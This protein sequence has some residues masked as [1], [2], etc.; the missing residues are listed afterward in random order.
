MRRFISVILILFFMNCGEKSNTILTIGHRGAMGHETENTIASIEKALDLNVDMIEI[1]VFRI[2]SGEIVVFHDEK[3]DRLTNG[4]GEIES[5]DLEAL[6]NLTVVGN[7]KIPL[8]SE[9]LDVINHKVPLNIEL[10]GPG[11]SEGVIHIINTYMENEG[12]A[13]DDFLISSFNWEELE[14]MR[15]INKDIEIAVLT[16]DNPLDAISIANDLNAVAI[17]PNYLSL[18]KKNVSEIKSRGFKIF[19]WTVNDT[20]QIS[21]MRKLGVD[22]IFTNYPE[23][24]N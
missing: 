13:L 17:N 16:E 9:V 21:N 3:I 6:K 1:D 14:H 7:H 23:R 18:T 22:G 5:L 12:W 19:T 20:E 2:T 4:S 24:V 10:K 8:L 15:R 11:T